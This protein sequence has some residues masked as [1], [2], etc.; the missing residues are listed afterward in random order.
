MATPAALGV[1]HAAAGSLPIGREREIRA[2]EQALLS[3]REGHGGSLVLSGP[4]G[5]GKTCLL[6]WAASRARSEGFAVR[7]GYGLRETLSPFFPFQQLFRTSGSEPREGS[8]PSDRS[9]RPSPAGAVEDGTV[10]LFEEERPGAFYETLSLL[11]AERPALLVGR[12]RASSLRERYPGLRSLQEHLWLSRV[13]GEGRIPPS[14][15][16]LLAERLERSLRARWGSVVALEGVEYLTSQNGFANVLRLVQ[17][18]RDVAAETTGRLLLS[19]RPGALTL[20]ELSALETEGEVRRAGHR[21]ATPGDEGAGTEGAALGST[22][23]ETLL[24]LLSRLE[25]FALEGPQLL[26][27]DDLQWADP[28]S[29]VALGFLA[30]NLRALPVL[31]LCALRD[32][33]EPVVTEEGTSLPEMLTALEQEGLLERLD[34][35]GLAEGDA[36]RLLERT[37]GGSL[38]NPRGSAAVEELLERAQGNPYFL[39]ECARQLEEEQLVVH[40][41][42]RTELRRAPQA[43]GGPIGADGAR[44][45]PPSLR[46]LLLRRLEALHPRDRELLEVGAIVG[47]EFDLTPIVPLLG[48]SE[49]DLRT[50]ARELCDRRRL[51][52]RRRTPDGEERWA[53]VHPMAWEVTLQEST[54]ERRAQLA[55]GLASWWVLARPEEV[56]TVA[57]LFHEAG[58][59]SESRPW[60]HRALDRALEARAPELSAT[61]IRWLGACRRAREASRPEVGLVETEVQEEVQAA[62]RLD[63]RGGPRLADQLLASLSAEELPSAA[64]VEVRAARCWTMPDFDRE[65]AGGWI[66]ATRRELPLCRAERRE[67]LAARLGAAE[68]VLRIKH[69]DWEGGLSSA[70]DV[71]SLPAGAE[72]D[73]WRASGASSAGWCLVQLGRFAEARKVLEAGMDVAEARG[74]VDTTASLSNTHAW[75]GLHE[76]H[77]REVLEDLERCI[78]VSE[79]T[80]NFRS[81]VVY[82]ANLA[83]VLYDVGEVARAEDLYRKTLVTTTRFQYTSQEL[84]SRVGLA[85]LLVCQRRFDEARKEVQR[86]GELEREVH[87]D[88]HTL[89]I[90]LLR[91]QVLAGQGD[92]TGATALVEALGASGGARDPTHLSDLHRVRAN[93]L[94]LVGRRKEAGEELDRALEAARSSGN[95]VQEAW[96]LLGIAWHLDRAGERGQGRVRQEEARAIYHELGF[97]SPLP[98]EVMLDAPEPVVPTPLPPSAAP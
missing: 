8:P 83:G 20:R 68:S 51:L 25:R 57:R 88:E 15:L 3:S 78:V 27:L 87:S 38:E 47:S 60:F 72:E 90:D 59:P 7:W 35:R 31:L 70:Q 98:E 34:L 95:R 48:R 86:A 33:E 81:G 92:L 46:R 43:A 89:E 12:E 91:A 21:G 16:E 94:H 71:L 69:G 32:D 41:G 36:V 45:I 66:E 54:A 6:Q 11:A 80:G 10:L 37:L 39:A 53:F 17:F 14:P 49:T 26:I 62:L 77:L 97:E 64:R 1:P 84:D 73:R 42:G 52:E 24:R 75:L 65:G 30:R 23:A 55:K 9:S 93:L 44:G 96:T 76:G 13:E 67:V 2:I 29:V 5:I 58:H 85:G 61:Y 22:S 82:E 4:G 18:L 63:F 50:S 19:I 40:E 28:R 56:D 74:L 79:A